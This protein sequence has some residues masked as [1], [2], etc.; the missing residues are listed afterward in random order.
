MQGVLVPN[1]RKGVISIYVTV[2]YSVPLS[3]L[4]CLSLVPVAQWIEH[5]SPKTGVVRSIRTRDATTFR[6]RLRQGL[7]LP[8][9]VER[10]AQP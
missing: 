10:H 7:L 6:P 2:F 8:A 3:R 5:R 4:W 1:V 9:R